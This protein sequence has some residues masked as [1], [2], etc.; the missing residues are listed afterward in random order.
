MEEA[1]RLYMLGQAD[2]TALIGDDS[3][4]TSPFRWYRM[5]IPQNAAMPAVAQDTQSVDRGEAYTQLGMGDWCK[6]TMELTVF[7][8]TPAA[9]DAV[10]LE[11]LRAIRK[12]HDNNANGT[13]GSMAG[14]PVQYLQITS[15]QD[16]F[17]QP[18]ANEATGYFLKVGTIE[19]THME[20]L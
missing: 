15:E 18:A 7:A 19:I 2:L 17:I 1:L 6:R 5:A 14:V 10:W 4:P 13:V 20:A 3:S 12:F 9:A 16:D 8:R 11:I